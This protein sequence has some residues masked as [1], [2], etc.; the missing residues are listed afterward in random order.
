MAK[1]LEQNSENSV[2]MG[3]LQVNRFFQSDIARTFIINTQIVISF[4]MLI[5]YG[6]FL[7]FKKAF[8]ELD[9]DHDKLHLLVIVSTILVMLQDMFLPL[10]IYYAKKLFQTIFYSEAPLGH[11]FIWIMPFMLISLG[12]VLIVNGRIRFLGYF[13]FITPLLL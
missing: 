4:L 6:V 2:I 8:G 13:I 1:E 5:I 11:Y 9:V 3:L 12:M 7:K 10:T